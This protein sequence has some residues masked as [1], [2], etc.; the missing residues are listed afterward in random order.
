MGLMGLFEHPSHLRER[1]SYLSRPTWKYRRLRTAAALS[2]AAL[3][4]FCVLPM[5]NSR[6]HAQ[7]ATAAAASSDKDINAKVA[8]LNLDT[9]TRDDVIAVFGEPGSYIWGNKTLDKNNLPDQ[10]PYIMFYNRGFMVEVFGGRVEELRFEAEGEFVFHDSLRVG[11][12]LEDV[13][14]VMGSPAETVAGG[15]LAFKDGVLYKDIGGRKGYCYYARRNQGIRIFC[16]NYR[17]QA[18]YVTRKGAMPGPTEQQK[19]N[20]IVDRTDYPFVDDPDLHGAWV[21]VDFVDTVDQ[22]TPGHQHWGDLFLKEMTFNDGGKTTG[23]WTWTKGLIIHPG[24]KTASHYEIKTIDG[25]ACLFF[26]WKSGDYGFRH[27]TPK[28]YVLTRR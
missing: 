8:Q 11:S 3:L 18:I 6:A 23:L 2:A 26:E 27:M 15:D 7:S 14:K 24:N 10:E 25:K 1:L 19:R 5:A 20:R 28:Y 13:L 9:A 21:S 22:F 17:V 12:T 4:F 16:N